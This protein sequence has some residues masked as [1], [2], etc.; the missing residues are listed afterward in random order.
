MGTFLKSFDITI[1]ILGID[2]PSALCYLHT[3]ASG[4]TKKFS[5][6][7]LCVRCGLEFLARSSNYQGHE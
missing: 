3:F 5:S 7:L 1:T 6:V 4:T 2:L